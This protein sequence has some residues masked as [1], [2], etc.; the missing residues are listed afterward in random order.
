MD[1]FLNLYKA[2]VC[3]HIEY[4]PPQYGHIYTKK[5]KKK[6]KKKK[7]QNRERERT[8]SAGLL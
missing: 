1:I 2:L 8:E 4:M 3:P 5:K 7:R 6:K